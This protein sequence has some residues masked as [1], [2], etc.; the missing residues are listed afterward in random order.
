MDYLCAI[1][2]GSLWLELSGNIHFSCQMNNSDM[3][4]RN[5]FILCFSLLL[6][7]NSLSQGFIL[8]KPRLDYDGEQLRISYDLISVKKTDLFFVWVESEKVNGEYIRMKS[9]MGDVGESIPSGKNKQIYW[10]PDKDTVYLNEEVFIEVKAEKY[11]KSYNK[12]SM[13]LMS[14]VFPGLGQAKVR[15]RPCWLTGVVAYGAL[16][17][18]IIANRSF[19]D[20]YNSYRIEEDPAKRSELLSLAQKQGNISDALLISGAGLWAANIVWMA[21]IP[22]KYKPL[23]YAPLSFTQGGHDNKI[24][25]LTLKFNFQ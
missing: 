8:S 4:L 11:L 13:M 24:A 23:K 3:I 7:E 1:F 6:F 16:A 22:N 25:M 12:A 21:L 2:L 19:T 18:G 20:T 5:F 17:G 15:S 9:L 14:T 10:T